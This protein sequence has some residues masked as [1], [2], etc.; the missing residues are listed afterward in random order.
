MSK[1]KHAEESGFTHAQQALLARIEADLKAQL[2]AKPKRLAHSFGVA[3]TCERLAR[4]YGANPFLARAAGLLHDWCKAE[5]DSALVG[6]ARAEGVDLGVDL[7]RVRPLLHGI[8]A[9][10]ELPARYPE[11]PQEVWDAIA[12]HT[13][14]SAHM[15]P[16][17][18]ALFV[19]DGIEPHRP[20]TPGIERTR[21][22]VGKA[23][24]P[25]LYWESFVGGIVY[26][27]EG[28]R[29]LYPGTVDVYNALVAQRDASKNV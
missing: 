9:S 1:H 2:A 11:L 16:L 8:L 24:L 22:L 7:D 18:M 14:G 4:L 3:D 12:V 27:L 20:S 6:R 23:T 15:T 21:S 17:G 10:R 26:V 29:Y 13:T 19:A 28:G 5:P 25:D